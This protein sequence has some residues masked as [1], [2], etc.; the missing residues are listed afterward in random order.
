MLGALE[1]LVRLRHMRIVEARGM[2]D[3]PAFAHR[4]IGHNGLE[5][6]ERCVETVLRENVAGDFIET[7]GDAVARVFSCEPC[8][9]PMGIHRA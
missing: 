6:L 5:N 8:S 7:G 1:R 4:M 9:R 3:F 2:Q